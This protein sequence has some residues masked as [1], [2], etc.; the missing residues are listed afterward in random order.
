MTTRSGITANHTRNCHHDADDREHSLP[1][2]RSNRDTTR[3]LDRFGECYISS[4][5][6]RV[7]CVLGKKT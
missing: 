5:V 2:L 7:N 6:S 1:L 3:P 4:P